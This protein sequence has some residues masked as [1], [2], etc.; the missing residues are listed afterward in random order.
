MIFAPPSTLSLLFCGSSELERERN[1][2]SMW[3]L[4]LGVALGQPGD[5]FSVGDI[6]KCAADFP[7]VRACT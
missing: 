6:A 5:A 3:A 1:M 2:R 7:D 4:I